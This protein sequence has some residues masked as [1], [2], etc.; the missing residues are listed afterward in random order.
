MTNPLDRFIM[1]LSNASRRNRHVA[2][3]LSESQVRIVVEQMLAGG[4]EVGDI[5]KTY[6][7]WRRRT[8][9]EILSQRESRVSS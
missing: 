7:Q 2:H 4:H 3:A 9:V 8:C 5:D 1:I 6:V